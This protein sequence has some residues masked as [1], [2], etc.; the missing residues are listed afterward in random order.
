MLAKQEQEECVSGGLDW[1]EPRSPRT[2]PSEAA[3]KHHREHRTRRDS[4]VESRLFRNLR[5]TQQVRIN[6]LTCRTAVVSGAAAL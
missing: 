3:A 2:Q 1:S 5:D 4:A 6:P